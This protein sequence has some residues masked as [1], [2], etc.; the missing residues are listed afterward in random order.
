M[1]QLARLSP[2]QLAWRRKS[3]E[4]NWT[5]ILK[6][7]DQAKSI[8]DFISH[9]P[10]LSYH[11][12][13]RRY[14]KYK[15]GDNSAISDPRGCHFRIFSN[16]QEEILAALI[17]AKMEGEKRQFVDRQTVINEAIIYFRTLH[18]E[19]GLKKHKR[20]FSSGW[21][22]GFK[23]RNGFSDQSM[24]VVEAGK[25]IHPKEKEKKVFNCKVELKIAM[26]NFGKNFVFNMDEVNAVSF[27]L[28][29]RGWGI[30][31]QKF[32]TKIKSEK[33]AKASFTTIPT[34]TANGKLLKF[35]WICPGKTTLAIRRANLASQIVSLH[36]P[37]GWTN[38]DSMIEYMKSVILFYTKGK[39]CALL[40]DSYKAHWTQKAKDFAKANNI[41]L[42]QIPEGRTG[43]FQPPD[44]SFNAV[45]K[46]NRQKLL[47]EAMEMGELDLEG[48][49]SVITRAWK[50]ATLVNKETILRG[51]EPL[52]DLDLS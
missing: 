46:R 18:G 12:V 24:K 15:S 37:S 16:E 52:K 6:E 21:V 14:R 48:R 50:A 30:K 41:Q 5:T 35:A 32:K 26:Q 40:L 28:P 34:V 44:V 22:Q 36:T 1:P 3:S 10:H 27:C 17:R 31:G 11:T 8:K 43:E 25:F 9:N 51:W 47:R 20:S 45:Y 49:H 42:I 38:E 23:A 4:L 33:Q 13:A 29:S 7:V 2:F 19:R 39:N